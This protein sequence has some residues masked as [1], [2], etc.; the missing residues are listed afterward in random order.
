[1]ALASRDPSLIER[2]NGMALEYLIRADEGEPH[3]SPV[4]PA[5]SGDTG[6][7]IDRD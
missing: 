1:M 3:A 7:D 6:S 5:I 2:Y 4:H